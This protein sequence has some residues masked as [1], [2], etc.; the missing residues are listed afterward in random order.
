MKTYQAAI[1]ETATTQAPW[2]LMPAGNKKSMRL[3]ISKFILERMKW[4]QMAHPTLPTAQQ[5]MLESCNKLLLKEKE[6][7]PERQPEQRY[8][9]LF[10]KRGNEGTP[11]GVAFGTQV[12]AILHKVSGIRLAVFT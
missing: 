6:P 1:R 7:S 5:E 8:G 3:I 11:F 9:L 2:C 12:K 10:Q 4:M